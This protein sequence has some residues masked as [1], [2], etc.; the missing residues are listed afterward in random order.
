MLF[1][2]CHTRYSLHK[3]IYTH[4]TGIVC[5][6]IFTRPLL[7]LSLARA[8]EYMLVDALL[9]AEPI[10]HFADYVTDPQKYL[11]LTDSV[12]ELVQMSD[13]KVSSV[14]L[15]FFFPAEINHFQNLKEAQAI[16]NR[17]T[18]RDLY[19]TVDYKVFTWEWKDNL[20]KFF[21]PEAIVTAAKSHNPKNDEERAALEEL[22]TQHIIIDQAVL[23]YGMGSTNPI[24]KIRFYSKR[25]PHGPYYPS[26][27]SE[28]AD[29]GSQSVPK[30]NLGTSRR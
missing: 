14:L 9:V 10:M 19:K 28:F 5:V 8:I 7:T 18:S 4:K 25:K 24:D 26:S 23:H 27:R 13:D 29:C 30:L 3:L 11:H 22:S 20:C 2:L 16:L 21:N 15:F 1:E 17:I 6:V 12:I